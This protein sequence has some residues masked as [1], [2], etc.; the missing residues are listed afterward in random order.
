[1]IYNLL[2]QDERIRLISDINSENNKARKQESFKASEVAGGRLEQFVKEK[3]LGELSRSS[4]KEMPIVSSVNVQKAVTDKKAT[5]YKKG[6]DRRFTNTTPEQESTLKLIYRDMNIDEKLNTANKNYVYQDQ[7]IGMIIPKNGKLICRILKMHQIDAIPSLYDP[8]V[9]DAY[10]ISTFDRTMYT[11][12]DQD[13]TDRDT[14]TGYIGRSSRSAASQ[15][16]DLGIAEKYQ[17][18]KYV[19]RYLVWSKDYNFMMNGMG[20]VI[21]PETGEPS[22]EIEII[23]PI[24]MLPFFEVSKDKDFEYFVRSSNS[25]TDFT[26]QF[27]SQLSDLSNNIKM[28]GYAV[29]ILKAP[30]DL[31][32]EN[33]VIGASMLL[34]LPTDDPDKE[35]DFAFASPNSNIGEI[36]DAIDKLLNYFVTSEG[37]GGSVVNSRGETE[38]ASSGID[39]YLMMLSRV[40]AHQDDYDKFKNC[41]K[42]IFK[43]IRAWLNVASGSDLLEDKYKVVLPEDTEL[44]IDFMKPEMIQTESEKLANIEKLLDLGLMSKKMAIMEWHNIDDEEKAFDILEDIKEDDSFD[45]YKEQI[46]QSVPNMEQTP[47]EGEDASEEESER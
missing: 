20:E 22:N 38:R 30:S 39:R 28:N 17:Y 34:K 9:A 26:I 36:S 29:G 2:N 18:Q 8:E 6:V 15:D 21:D 5:V 35:V 12:L 14:A 31:Q 47:M 45:P 13:K 23:N 19:E 37:L 46:D 42:Q 43:I 25:L 33:Q 41:E 44:E 10:I 24:G 27:N 40:E 4:V 32:P 7:T 1:M 11:Q 3:L 16:N